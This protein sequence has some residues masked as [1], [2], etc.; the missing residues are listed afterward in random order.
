ME[1]DRKGQTTSHVFR[2]AVELRSA[3]DV[4]GSHTIRLNRNESARIEVNQNRELRELVSAPHSIYCQRVRSPHARSST[5]RAT[6]RQL[7][8]S[9]HFNRLWRSGGV[10]AK[11]GVVAAAIRHLSICY[12]SRGGDFGDITN[13]VQLVATQVNHLLCPGKLCLFADYRKAGWVTL[14]RCFLETLLL[15][16][17]SLRLLFIGGTSLAP[18]GL[19]ETTTV[20]TGLRWAFAAETSGLIT[21]CSPWPRMPVRCFSFVSTAIWGY[22]ENG[23]QIAVGDVAGLFSISRKNAGC[24]RSIGDT[25]QRELVEA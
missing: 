18:R 8:Q 3:N 12:V 17:N 10:W 9:S 19:I 20:S 21:A 4:L 16:S 23:K 22:Y 25:G 13:G 24:W 2:G 14:T 1:V 5:G 15:P 11:Q 6:E 7:R